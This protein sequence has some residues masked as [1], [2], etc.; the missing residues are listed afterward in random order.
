MY[1]INLWYTIKIDF[2]REGFLLTINGNYLGDFDYPR[3][4]SPYFTSVYFVSFMTSSTFRFYVDNVKITIIQSVD[5]I[6]PGNVALLVI[7]PIS[8]I[9]FYLFYKKRRG[10]K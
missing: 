8:I 1:T 5:Y 3:Y 6:H 9:I 10:K 7:I 4:D 2:D